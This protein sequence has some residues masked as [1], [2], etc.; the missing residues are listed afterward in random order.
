[1]RKEMSINE[2]AEAEGYTPRQIRQMCIDGK[3][4]GAHKIHGGRKWLIPYT[5]PVEEQQSELI[6]KAKDEHLSDIRKL[7]LELKEDVATP[8]IEKA[9]PDCLRPIEKHANSS[10]YPLEK[11]VPIP[12]FWRKVR[13]WTEKMHKYLESCEDTISHILHDEQVIK[14]IADNPG[15]RKTD[16]LDPI[17]KCIS[18]KQLGNTLKQLYTRNP[19]TGGLETFALKVSKF[20]AHKNVGKMPIKDRAS[21]LD[22]IER[23]IVINPEICL[24]FAR[25]KET[26]NL[27]RLFKELRLLE[28]EIQDYL[29]RILWRR[30]YV[31]YKCSLCPGEQSML[32]EL[33]SE[34]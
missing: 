19:N 12:E 6:R 9:Y 15:H 26:A 23:S 13:L 11:H 8:T 4:P 30:E 34:D 31:K 21:E 29:R 7:L 10:V 28:V 3:I 14:L 17:L 27:V 18:D 5:K 1:M 25:S 24:Y 16:Y 2:Y 32:S 22:S 20:D 33:K